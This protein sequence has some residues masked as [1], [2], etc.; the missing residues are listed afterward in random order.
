MYETHD[1]PQR[2]KIK[3]LFDVNTDFELGFTK[4]ALFRYTGMHT[5]CDLLAADSIRTTNRRGRPLKLPKDEVDKIEDLIYTESFEA[6]Q[7]LT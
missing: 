4:R 7:P 2:A 6:S 1:T 5:G 3:A